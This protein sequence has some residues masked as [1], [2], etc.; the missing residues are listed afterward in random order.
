MI[1]CF[2]FSQIS[3]GE[4]NM[5]GYVSNILEETLK[6]SF[7]RK[8]LYTGKHAQLV[9]MCL[10]PQED[11]GMEVHY[12]VDQFF[13]IEQGSAEVIIDGAKTQVKDDFAIIVPA[14]AQHN[15][16]NTGSIEL[17]LYTIYSPPNHPE[18]TIH[19]TKKEAEANEHH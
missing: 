13:R 7:F 5:T 3:S 19:K 6:N 17:K 10:Q 4:P 8:V 15:I 2:C 11:I 16:V 18:G 9:V 1:V 12:N 14:G